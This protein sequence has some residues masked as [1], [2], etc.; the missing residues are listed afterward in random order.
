M[1]K[2]VVFVALLAAGADSEI[3]GIFKD[4]GLALAKAKAA[5]RDH[6]KDAVGVV[7]RWEVTC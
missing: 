6:F 2:L 7:Q 3:V 5:A 1:P 4:E